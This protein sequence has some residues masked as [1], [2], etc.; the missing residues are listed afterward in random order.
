MPVGLHPDWNACRKAKRQDGESRL[1]RQ[2]LSSDPLQT[3][4]GE[5]LR[6]YITRRK[7]KGRAADNC[8]GLTVIRSPISQTLVAVTGFCSILLANA[9]RDYMVRSQGSE[10][11]SKPPAGRWQ[12]ICLQCLRKTLSPELL[13][14]P[15]CGHVP[16]DECRWNYIASNDQDAGSSPAGFTNHH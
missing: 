5:C 1:S 6:D 12:T 3:S 13:T 10:E 8:S 11:S 15:S 4:R 2:T 7:P 16:R 14:K 9:A